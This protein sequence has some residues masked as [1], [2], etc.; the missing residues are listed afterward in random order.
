MRRLEVSKSTLMRLPLY[1]RT[2]DRLIKDGNRKVLSERLGEA[3]HIDATQVRRDLSSLGDFGKAGV[4]Y[5]IESILEVLDDILGFKNTTEAVLVGI[6]RLGSALYSY[7][8]FQKY[9]MKIAAL[10]DVDSEKVGTNLDGTMILDVSELER[11][12]KRLNVQMGI[13]A[14]PDFAAQAVADVMVLAG[15][16]A[17][18]NFAPVN[19]VVPAGVHVRDEDLAVGL[20]HLSRDLVIMNEKI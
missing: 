6:G 15:I 3:M 13:I 10:F 20:T 18:W 5:D 19:L 4:G 16:V 12:V 8:G 1:Y 9:G 14:V 7:P 17:I 2:L 11:V